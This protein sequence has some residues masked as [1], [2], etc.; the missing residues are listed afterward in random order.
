MWGCSSV[1]PKFIYYLSAEFLMGRSLTNVVYNLGLE[2]NYG[3]ALQV[4]HHYNA[5]LPCG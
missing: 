5:P 4:T 2:G 1:D 3:K